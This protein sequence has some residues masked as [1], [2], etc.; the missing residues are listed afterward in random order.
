[1]RQTPAGARKKRC[2]ADFCPLK[3]EFVLEQTLLTPKINRIML[4]VRFKENIATTQIKYAQ[5]N[6]RFFKQILWIFLL[7]IKI[8]TKNNA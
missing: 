5:R 1:L 7:V 3:P 4:L 8:E 2:F 6:T